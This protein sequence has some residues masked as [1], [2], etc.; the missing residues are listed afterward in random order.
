MHAD[1]ELMLETSFGFLGFGLGSVTH[2]SSEEA[3]DDPS[4]IFLDKSLAPF[5]PIFCLDFPILSFPG[6]LFFSSFFLLFSQLAC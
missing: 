4:L 6:F 2:L 3:W 1:W 5:I